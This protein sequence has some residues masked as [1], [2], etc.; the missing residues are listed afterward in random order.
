MLQLRGNTIK[1]LLQIMPVLLDLFRT[2]IF[3]HLRNGHFRLMRVVQN[4]F[5]EIFFRLVVLLGIW[6]MMLVVGVVFVPVLVVLVPPIVV[7]MLVV[8]VVI[9]MILSIIIVAVRTRHLSEA[10][11]AS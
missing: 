5:L 6:V 4:V 3:Y 9:G 2:V 1:K 10:A 11:S 7:L 8:R